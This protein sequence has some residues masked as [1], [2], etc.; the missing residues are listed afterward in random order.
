MD[1]GSAHVLLTLKRRGNSHVSM[2][3][4][5][6]LECSDFVFGKRFPNAYNRICVIVRLGTLEQERLQVSQNF[7]GQIQKYWYVH[8]ICSDKPCRF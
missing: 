1:L 2:D 4:L 3:F 7:T 5:S 8:H 6:D